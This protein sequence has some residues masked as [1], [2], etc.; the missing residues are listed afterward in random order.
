MLSNVN[1]LEKTSL[2]GTTEKS[3]RVEFDAYMNKANNVA[4][5]RINMYM[6]CD[7]L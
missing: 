1:R 2:Y 4:N 3:T 7:L 6:I 5:T